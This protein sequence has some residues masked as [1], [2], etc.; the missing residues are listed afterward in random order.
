[1]VWEIAIKQQL[2][3]LKPEYS[4]AETASYG[5][6]NHL[7]ILPVSLPYITQ[8][9]LLPLIDKDPFDRMIVATAFYKRITLISKK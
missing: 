1:M 4:L 8:Y 9:S 3:K 2:K 5:L 7:L 6:E